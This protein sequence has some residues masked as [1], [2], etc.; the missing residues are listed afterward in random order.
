[1][2]ELVAQGIA[3]NHLCQ[4]KSIPRSYWNFSTLFSKT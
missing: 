2:D 1:M 3:E 4:E